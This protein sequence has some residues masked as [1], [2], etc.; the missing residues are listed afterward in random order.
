[1]IPAQEMT[2]E[3]L[4]EFFVESGALLKGHFLLSSGLHSGQYMQCALLLADPEKASLMGESLAKL[5]PVKPTLVLSPAMGGL[6]IGHETARALKVRAYFTE[7]ENGL[8]TLRRGFKLKKGEQVIVVEDVVTTGKSSQEV[9]RLVCALGG[10]VLG[11]LAIVDRSPKAPDFNVPLR[12]LLRLNIPSFSPQACPLCQEGR[13]LVKPG[14][15]TV[16]K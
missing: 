16:P 3:K 14:S 2:A 8:M 7:R 1:M 10:E 6:I 4:N 12:T 15:R 11:V 5:A 9:I 13:P